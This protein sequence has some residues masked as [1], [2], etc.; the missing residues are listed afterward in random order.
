M[1]DDKKKPKRMPVKI[2]DHVAGGVYANSMM[3]LHTEREFA[4]DFLNML[5]PQGTVTAR[6]IVRPENI[7]R[8][9]KALQDN[10]ERY[11]ARF[12]EIKI[13]PD[14]AVNPEVS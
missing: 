12:G 2:P 10:V 13:P 9:L 1:A 14:N 11:E 3:V 5:P 8:M 6:V 4:L 7:K